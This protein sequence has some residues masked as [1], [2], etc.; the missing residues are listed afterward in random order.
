MMLRD[1]PLVEIPMATSSV[2]A[3]AID[4]TQKNQFDAH[5]VGDRGEI[6]GFH[7]QRDRGN[8][9]I[10]RGRKHA[11]DGPIVGVRGRPSVAENNQLAALRQALMDGTRGARRSVPIP[12]CAT[13]A[14]RRASSC[15]LTRMDAATSSTISLGLLFLFAEK[16]I[17]ESGFADVIPQFPMLEEN[18]HRLPQRVIENL[19]QFLMDERIL[20][21]RLEE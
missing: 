14:R 5:I 9:P 10:S 11:V 12:R 8:R 16:R 6:R 7:G 2:R 15:A 21:G 19:H 17:E 13:R 4:L 20:S 18:V 1:P 3:C